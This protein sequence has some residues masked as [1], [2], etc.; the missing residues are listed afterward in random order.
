M[1]VIIS[2]LFVAIFVICLTSSNSIGQHGMEFDAENIE[3]LN[4]PIVLHRLRRDSVY[5]DKF[6]STTCEILTNTAGGV[7][8]GGVTGI[9]VGSVIGGFAG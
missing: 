1:K 2:V 3:Y 7:G 5:K 8:G 4:V 6:I 9:F